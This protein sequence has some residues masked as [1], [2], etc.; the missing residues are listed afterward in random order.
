M[1]TW[2]QLKLVLESLSFSGTLCVA[3]RRPSGPSWLPRRSVW[4]L[5][6][7]SMQAVSVSQ[8]LALPEGTPKMTLLYFLQVLVFFYMKCA[9]ETAKQ[10]LN[11]PSRDSQ[12]L[13]YVARCRQQSLC[14]KE[15][16]QTW[17]C[18]D[19]SPL[20]AS[21]SY[22]TWL[23]HRGTAWNPL[24]TGQIKCFLAFIWK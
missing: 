6:R 19:L 14:L 21:V 15:G 5:S 1:G 18:W 9:V 22:L 12:P 13:T 20:A 8:L 10:T 4:S 11:C 7:V 17:L 3:A 2:T 23:K 24:L 16:K